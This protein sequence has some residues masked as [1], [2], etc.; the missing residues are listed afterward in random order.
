VSRARALARGEASALSIGSLGPVPGALLSPL[1]SASASGTRTCG[2]RSEPSISPTR[3]PGCAKDGPTWAFL[4]A[5]LHEPDLV[6]TP[7]ISEQRMVVV[8]RTHRLAG[9]AELRP[10]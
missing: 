10:G 6:L 8:P 5:P 1:L 7:L 9:R 4:Y 2:W 3:S